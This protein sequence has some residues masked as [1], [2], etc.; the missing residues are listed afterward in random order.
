MERLRVA[1]REAAAQCRRARLPRIEPVVDLGTLAG[2]ADLPRPDL[3]VA[4]RDGGSLADLGEPASGTWT[5]V[6]GPEGG[7]E[8]AELDALR[9][10]PRLCLGPHVLRAETAPIAAV[11]L[12]LSRSHQMFREW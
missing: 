3:V 1:A 7:L 6:V 11:A 2:R 4:D 8:P 10:A 5:V 12:L 9:D